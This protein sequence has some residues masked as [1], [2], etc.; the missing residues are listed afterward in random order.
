MEELKELDELFTDGF[1]DEDAYERRRKQIL[2][3][4]GGITAAPPTT[5]QVGAHER[6]DKCGDMFD[7]YQ[8]PF[9]ANCGQ[10][11]KASGDGFVCVFF[12]QS[13]LARSLKVC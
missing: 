6:C 11:T 5:S 10:Q 8:P 4:A 13:S 2:D 12:W 1:I 9:C 7:E 3:E